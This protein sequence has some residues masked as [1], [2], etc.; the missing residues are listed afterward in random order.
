MLSMTTQ[1]GVIR[2]PAHSAA[3]ANL[4]AMPAQHNVTDPPDLLHASS[5]AAAK[6]MALY[7]E[8]VKIGVVVEFDLI[9]SQAQ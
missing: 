2:Q 4:A 1:P 8:C 6:M 3:V 9:L 7:A 5:A